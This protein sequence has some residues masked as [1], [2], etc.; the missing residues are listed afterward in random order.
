ML[1]YS[2]FWFFVKWWPII[3]LRK[4]PRF[5]FIS[6]CA[7]FVETNF[8]NHTKLGENFAFP[9][10]FHTCKLG[11][12]LLVSHSSRVFKG[13]KKTKIV[14]MNMKKCSETSQSKNSCYSR[15]LRNLFKANSYDTTRT[16]MTSFCCL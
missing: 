16:S 7:N 15:H 12:I 3:A 14:Q 1:M 4:I 13:F 11:D 5:H 10:N 8:A 9:Q 6:W 2:N